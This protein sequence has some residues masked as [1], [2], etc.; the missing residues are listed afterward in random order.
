[1]GDAKDYRALGRELVERFLV[2]D[3]KDFDLDKVP[4]AEKGGLD[5]STVR[6]IFRDCRMRLAALQERLAANG[7]HGILI[8]LQGMDT[9]GKDS[10][11][12]H[13]MSGMNPQGTHV[14]SFKQPSVDE[15]KHDF[16][17]RVHA[18]MPARG[19]VGVFNRSHY[20]DV[21][22]ARVHAERLDRHAFAGDPETPAFWD[23]RLEDIRHFER[24]LTRQNFCILK[25]FLHISPDEQRS[26][27]LQRIDRPEKRW[28]FDQSDLTERTFWPAYH[29]AYQ[30][31]VAGTATPYAPWLVVPSDHKWFSRF[32]VMEAL[33][34]MLE[35]INPEPPPAAPEILTK[36]S[37]LRRRLRNDTIG[38]EPSNHDAKGKS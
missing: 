31:A 37:D 12:R 29:R 13:V 7:E 5:K 24:Y 17:W 18:A 20:E 15:Q 30:E 27:I 1:M 4:T 6:R 25:V 19:Q 9:A 35:T 26:R 22:V 10:L 21:L 28:K 8:V 14:T 32:V 16:L 36:L 23:G 2:R 11:I 3:G 38:D 33:I 34:A